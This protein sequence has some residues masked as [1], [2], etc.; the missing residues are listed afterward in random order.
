M[1]DDGPVVVNPPGTER[2]MDWLVAG[3]AVH[4]VAPWVVV[5]HPWAIAIRA[6]SWLAA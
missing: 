4:V 2:M 1:M 3:L 5:V 6:A